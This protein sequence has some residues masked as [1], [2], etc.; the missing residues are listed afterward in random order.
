M[1][2]LTIHPPSSQTAPQVCLAKPSCSSSGEK[3]APADVWRPG[4]RSNVIAAKTPPLSCTSNSRH[5]PPVVGTN[6]SYQQQTPQSSVDK[7]Q[8]QHHQLTNESNDDG[9]SGGSFLRQVSIQ[10]RLA[11]AKVEDGRKRK[12]WRSAG[13]WKRRSLNGGK[14]TLLY[15][16]DSNGEIRNGLFSRF[17]NLKGKKN[18]TFNVSFVLFWERL[19]NDAVYLPCQGSVSGEVKN[20]QNY[21]NN[22][23]Y[24]I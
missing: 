7:G 15:R 23:L 5:F 21:L 19:W 16:V 20:R 10:V 2:N 17:L 8:P 14:Y 22:D 4:R 6:T 9:G 13:R 3:S 11:G 1:L 18:E 24:Q 12:W